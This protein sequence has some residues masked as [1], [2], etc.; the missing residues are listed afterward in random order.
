VNAAAAKMPPPRAK[1]LKDVFIDIVFPI[2]FPDCIFNIAVCFGLWNG[3]FYYIDG[4]FA[5][6]M[7]AERHGPSW[8]R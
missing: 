2:F 5:G 8:M 7:K 6:L 3:R 1:V 4:L